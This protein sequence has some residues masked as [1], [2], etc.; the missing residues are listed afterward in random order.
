MLTL[1]KISMISKAAGLGLIMVLMGSGMAVARDDA[2]VLP[3]DG[4]LKSAGAGQALDG[5][6]TFYFGN[7]SHPAVEKKFGNFVT[8]KKTNNF[9]KPDVEACN[10]AMLAALKT[11]QERAHNEGGNA[12]INI[13]S[14][15]KKNE[16]S[17][18]KEFE[19]H[20]GA[21][22]AGVAL[23]GDVVKLKK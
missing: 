14:Y 22:V 17:Y 8:N 20:A 15:Y 5:S 3:V 23:K 12:V 19:C 10:W 9:G 18:D 21:F 13:K 4:A 6:V 16:V 2:L 7:S 1:P 11:F